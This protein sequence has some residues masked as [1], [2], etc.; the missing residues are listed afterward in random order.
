MKALES[1]YVVTEHPNHP[2]PRSTMLTAQPF[3]RPQ[4]SKLLCLL[5][6]PFFCDFILYYFHYLVPPFFIFCLLFPFSIF[7]PYYL[8]LLYFHSSSYMS[9]SQ[10]C[11][12]PSPLHAPRW[13]EAQ[14]IYNVCS[15]IMFYFALM[16]FWWEPCEYYRSVSSPYFPFP[17]QYFSFP[18]VSIPF[19]SFPF[20]LFADV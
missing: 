16:F 11:S 20:L 1:W 6:S 13:V 19:L 14:L 4:V 10:P 3:A 9:F 18:C 15:Y 7:I 2:N 12:P 8:L 5:S 17:F